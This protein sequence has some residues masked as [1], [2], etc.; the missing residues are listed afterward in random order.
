MIG[1]RVAIVTMPP[2]IADLALS[3]LRE[4]AA[5]TMCA[6]YPAR[7]Q[8]AAKL[9]AD[10]PDLV[11]LG[12]ARGEDTRFAAGLA[13]PLSRAVIVALSRDGHRAILVR[14]FHPP[15]IFADVSLSDLTDA[16]IAALARPRI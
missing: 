6:A 16:V 14:G 12:L 11:L 4:R 2:I 10:D 13:R 1:I 5:V 9:G 8:A 7:A 3:A 15:R